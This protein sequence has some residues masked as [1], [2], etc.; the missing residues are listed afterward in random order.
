MTEQSD[1]EILPRQEPH[2]IAK[3]HQT[4]EQLLTQGKRLYFIGIGGI[5]MSAAAGIAKDEGYEVFGSDQ[6][7]LYAPAKDVLDE[8]GIPYVIPY[9][10]KNINEHPAD[11]YIASSGE[12]LDNPEIAALHAQSIPVFSFAELL[13][14]IAQENLRIVVAGTHGKST[15]AGLIGHVLQ[16]IDDSS[17]MTGAVLQE[18]DTNFHRG[19]GH[20]FVF[21]GDEYKATYEDITPKF[22]LYKPDILV[23]TNLE[24]DHPD[25]FESFE[26]MKSEFALLIASMPPDGLIIYNADNVELSQLVYHSEIIKFGY[27]IQEPSEFKAG[28]ID[29]G[30]KT[31]ITV[32]EK[33]HKRE[34]A[35]TYEIAL[36][37]KMNVYNALAG[38]AMLR[39]LNFSPELIKPNVESFY[40]VKRRFE[41]VGKVNDVTIID[42]YAHHPTAVRETIEAAKLRYPE[43]KVWAIF[44]PH[45]F[46]RTQATLAE[47]A[48]SFNSADEVLVSTIYPARENIK[49]ATITAEQVVEEIKKHQPNTRLVQDKKAA[50]S[51][52]SEEARPGDIILVM[53]VG[54]FNRLG[55][56]LLERLQ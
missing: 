12:G 45:T 11:A 28:K 15:T 17:F 38:I 43:K 42:D 26:I 3:D 25:L 5:G 53:A 36:P 9:D 35:N 41:I 52:L 23:L 22:H 39:A 2:A 48:L 1:I 24:Y 34:E 4:L 55:Y 56:E 31:S 46:S 19:H 47:L 49:N 33:V 32:M 14:V 10:E 37:G 16:N 27:S 40:G 20:Y 44:E 51:I 30:A 21:E 54:S 8:A 7:A 6:S 29:Y 50:L 18:Y 13:E